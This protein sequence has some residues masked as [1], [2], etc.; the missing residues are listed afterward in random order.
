[1]SSE[2]VSSSPPSLLRTLSEQHWIVASIIMAQKKKKI[3][4]V[5]NENKWSYQIE[6]N[7]TK[8]TDTVEQTFYDGNKVSEVQMILPKSYRCSGYNKNGKRCKRKVYWSFCN[9]HKD[10]C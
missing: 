5:G 7:S 4:W 3:Q 1:M 8:T 2:N 9:I 6:R 10:Q